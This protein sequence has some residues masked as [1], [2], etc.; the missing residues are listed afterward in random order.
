VSCAQN[1]DELFSILGWAPCG[2]HKK[3]ART[4]Y[5]ELGFLHPVGSA[6]HV[7]HYGVSGAQNVITL[8]FMLQWDRYGFGKKACRDTLHRHMCFCI[9]RDL[10]VT[11]GIRVSPRRK[12][13]SHYFS[14]SGGPGAVYIK[15]VP[16]HVTQILCFFH[17]V[18]SVSH[19]VQSKAFG[20]GN[21]DALFFMLGWAWSGFCK[22][23]DM[24]RYAK[25]VFLHPVGYAGHVVHSDASAA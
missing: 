6:G 3:H 2:L 14:C 18:G 10:P 24:P 8:F 19:I 1:L 22:K 13:S 16:G 11:W 4:R 15:S 12:I 21:V 23:R 7:V 17:P 20:A 9:R 5:D 25:L